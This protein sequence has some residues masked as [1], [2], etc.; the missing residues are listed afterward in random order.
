LD[1]GSKEEVETEEEEGVV[2]LPLLGK[3]GRLQQSGRKRHEA[4]M[5]GR[6]KGR[7]SWKTEGR[8][9]EAKKR[10]LLSRV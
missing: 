5:G 9:V 2:L 8:K 6:R 10:L 3:R 1:S 4:V 7:R